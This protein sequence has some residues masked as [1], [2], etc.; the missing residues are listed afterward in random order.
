M[1]ETEQPVVLDSSQK[2]KK[3]KHTN[4]FTK[5]AITRLARRAGVKSLSEDCYPI[6]RNLIRSK[7]EEL[8]RVMD[9]VNSEHQTKTLMVEDVYEALS[10]LG[11]NFTQSSDLGASTRAK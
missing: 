7:L 11:V 5:S 3:G 4:T 8:T 6:I 2:S 9:I 10:L 1:T